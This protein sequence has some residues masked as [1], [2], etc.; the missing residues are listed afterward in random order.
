MGGKSLPVLLSGLQ[1]I[2]SNHLPTP[3]RLEGI[4]RIEETQAHI[5]IREA[6]VNT[7][8]HAS[9]AEPGNIIVIREPDKIIMRN[10]GR[11]LISVDDFMQEAIVFAVIRLSKKCLCYW[12]MV[13][14][15]EVVLII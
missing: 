12:D 14:K 11:M 10:P 1:S 15:L 5:A 7:L 2:I 9:Y 13:K 6:L 3:F 4:T 8:V